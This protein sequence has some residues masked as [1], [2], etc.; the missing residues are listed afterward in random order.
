MARTDADGL[1]R[2]SRTLHYIACLKLADRA[3]NLLDR[4]DRQIEYPTFD[5]V[6]IVFIFFNCLKD[7]YVCCLTNL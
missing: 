6:S 2:K 1:T 3:L 5:Y 7:P 4:Y